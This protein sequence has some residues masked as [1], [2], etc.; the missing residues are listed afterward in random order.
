M[1]YLRITDIGRIHIAVSVVGETR[2]CGG[3]LLEEVIDEPDF[4]WLMIVSSHV[5][6]H[7]H[8]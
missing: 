4:E 5:K 8:A 7:P 1:I 6:V 2:V 3:E